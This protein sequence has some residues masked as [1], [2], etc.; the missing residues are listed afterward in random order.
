MTDLREMLDA[1]DSALDAVCGAADELRATLPDGSGLVTRETLAAVRD[2]CRMT[3]RYLAGDSVIEP[4][5]VTA[6]IDEV[7]AAL[8]PE[9]TDD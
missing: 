1:L 4:Q 7:L 5:E 2:L 8:T 9:P 3:G 6:A